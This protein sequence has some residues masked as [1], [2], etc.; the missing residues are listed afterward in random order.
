MH[1]LADH[2][3]YF[4]KKNKTQFEISKN[5]T[6]LYHTHYNNYGPVVQSG[7]TLPLQVPIKKTRKALR[8]AEASGSNPD[9]STCII[10]LTNYQKRK[11][12]FSNN[13]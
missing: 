8:E 4:F 5:I 7:R 9:R 11:S 3:L 6:T 12:L 10:I 2:L 1:F 13:D